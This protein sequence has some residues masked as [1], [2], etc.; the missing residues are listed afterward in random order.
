MLGLWKIMAKNWWKM[1]LNYLKNQWQISVW[2]YHKCQFIIKL[3]LSSEPDLW[4]T[5][6]G[7]IESLAFS[8]QELNVLLNCIATVANAAVLKILQMLQDFFL[9]IHFEA[10]TLQ[11]HDNSCTSNCRAQ[12]FQPFLS[13]FLWND[14]LPKTC[15]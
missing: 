10:P 14:Y 15:L 8:T 3:S 7:L 5:K 11:P 2:H 13:K 6:P 1:L 9:N 12:L 4:D